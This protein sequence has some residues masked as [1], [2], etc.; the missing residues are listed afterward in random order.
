MA[1]SSGKCWVCH[2]LAAVDMHH[3][4]PLNYGGDKDGKQVAL[5]A[6]CHDTLHREAEHY[7]K[8]GRYHILDT[9]Y[10]GETDK[11]KRIRRLIKILLDTKHAYI[12]DGEQDNDQRRM[13]QVSWDS[14]QELQMAHAVKVAL[15][16]TSLERAIKECVFTMYKGLK[17]KGRL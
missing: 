16:F 1:Y 2:E 13:S 8:H 5:C 7:D 17:N 12:I 6:K 3:C 15:G 10:A 9:S 14:T 4:A 11:G